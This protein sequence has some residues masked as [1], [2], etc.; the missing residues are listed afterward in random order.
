MDEVDIEDFIIEQ[1]LRLTQESQIP[2]KIEDMTIAEYLEYEKKGL[3]YT[4]ANIADFKE[5]LERIYSREIHRDQVVDFLWMPELMRDGLFARM[6]MEHHDDPGVVVFTSRAWGRLFDTRGP[7]SESER[8]I[9]GKGD[10]HGYWRDISTAGDFLGP[11]PSYTLIRDP[12]LRLFHRMIAYSIAGRSQAPEKV[13]VMD[14]F[15]L[16]GMDVGSVNVPYLLA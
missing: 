8:M 7:L 11:P 16:R 9:P 5:R 13:T 12:V 10:V 6:V 2:K 4:D 1:Y 3:E 15:Y 14:L